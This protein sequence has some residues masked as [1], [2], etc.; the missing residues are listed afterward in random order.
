[1]SLLEYRRK[2]DF[3]KTP[4]PSAGAARSGER[5]FTVQLH[6]ASHRHFDFR[7][8]L[9][10]VLKS[11]AVP[12]GPSFDPKVKRLAVQV[13]DHPLSYAQ[14]EGDIP[15][16]NYGAGHVDVFDSGSWEAEGDAR[17][18]LA[19]GELKF[20]LHGDIL[21]GS[22]VL[23]RTRKVGSRQQWLLIKHADAY[24]GARDA[25]AFVDPDT[26]RPLPLAQRHRVWGK[27]NGAAPLAANGKRAE[28]PPLQKLGKRETIDGAAFAPQ[29]CRAQATPPH[30]TD[31]LHEVKWDGY[32]IVATVARGKVRLWSRNGIEWTHK[33]PELA[34]AIAKLR[35][36][37]AQL[38][39]EMVS[40][41]QGRDDFNALQARLSEE[42]RDPLHYMLFD[43]PHLD[44][45][46]LRDLPLLQRKAVLQRLLGA[47]EQ[48]LLHYSEHQV[49]NGEAV[50]AQ[51]VKAGL[52]GIVSKRID[53][54]YAGTR[55]GD[56]VKVKT[57]PSDEFIV[58]GFTE[59]KGSRSGIGALL[60]A[61]PDG[62]TL[63]YAGR[64]GTG[65]GDAQ[66]RAL[67]KRLQ[68]HV[69]DEPPADIELMERRDRRLAIWVE[70]TL[71]IEV[72]HQGI[73]SQGLLRQPAF[74]T[75][76]EDKSSRD[77]ISEKSSKRA[78]AKRAVA[79][80]SALA[81]TRAAPARK[82]A[83]RTATPKR[84]ATA[85]RAAASDAAAAADAVRISHPERI[86]F[87]GTRISKGDV[88]VY[89]R[90]IAPLLLPE[91]V[92]RPLSVVRCPGGIGKACFFQKHLGAGWGEH[93]HGV[94]IRE[95]TGSNEYLC[96]D[97]AAGLLELVQMNVLEFHAWGARAND[98]E[99][100]DRIVFDLDPH[101]SVQWP[102]MRAAAREMR[103]HLA[104]AGLESFLRTSGGKGV[105]VVVPLKP[106]APWDAV[107]RFA[108]AFA[109]AMAALKPRDYVATA[110][111]KNRVGR[112]F[113][114]WLRNGR[115]A[116]SVA[117]YSLRARAGAGV[118]MPLDW[119]QLARLPSGDAFTIDNALAH[120]R[121]RRA[122]PWAGI[123]RVR[124]S[125]PR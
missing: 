121:K 109:D 72:Y 24:A 20:V 84:G 50:F 8:E 93:V 32:R 25:N 120:V 12:K 42:R 81:S 94:T 33:V 75:M 31:W 96:I 125:L 118:A 53:S 73:G 10:G 59:P 47:H 100:A 107:K 74:K 40:L 123:D 23:V 13:E 79:A 122:D 111:E 77:L 80:K 16:G 116:T 61:R 108:E 11:W 83:P 58:I 34:K 44:G 67:R 21:R 30:G 90:A 69:I 17:S 101:A 92:G 52:E 65:F 28:A 85:R 119:S 36:K 43:L 103:E 112:I 56:W 35:L 106:A 60:L 2:R 7:L 68:Q 57:R 39:G 54:R 62:K 97:D 88:A 4:E 124:Q 38:D 98:V 46:A 86:V 48:P 27:R 63:T 117:S 99:R 22:W 45:R 55:N 19:K 6:H 105:H 51:A 114:D 18:A 15:A 115:G 76:R 26:D 37:S 70:P 89:Y 64:V 71:V 82:Q 91:I 104:T 49:G 95:K 87:P 5:I 3:R 41:A 1:M 102:R 9:D 29:L 110:G 14:F 113:I 66:L 78:R